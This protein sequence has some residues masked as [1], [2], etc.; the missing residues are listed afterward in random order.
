[1][2]KNTL[3]NEVRNYRFERP[4]IKQLKNTY[5]ND[6]IRF[7]HPHFNSE[8]REPENWY[9]VEMTKKILEFAAIWQMEIS[10]NNCPSDLQI[11]LFEPYFNN[12]QIVAARIDEE[13]VMRDNFFS[14]P[15]IENEF[16]FQ[17]FGIDP[18]LNIK[19]DHRFDTRIVH[20][21]EKPTKVEISE[22]LNEGYILK[23]DYFENFKREVGFYQKIIGNVWVGRFK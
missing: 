14:K 16:P 8:P 2:D 9:I 18:N 13:K 3:L 22:L 17:Y 12:S 10:K 1:M 20:D 21:F 7:R 19:W 4:N 23:K 5:Q 11:W 6:Y 15:D